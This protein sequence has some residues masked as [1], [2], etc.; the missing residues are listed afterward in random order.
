VQAIDPIPAQSPAPVV[1]FTPRKSD[2][3]ASLLLGACPPAA[4]LLVLLLHLIL[5][6]HQPFTDIDAFPAVLLTAIIL[7]LLINA[8]QFMYKPARPIIRYY[9]PLATA[10]ILVLGVWDLF[11]LKFN[12]LPAVYFPA[13]HN[14][15]WAFVTDWRE[16]SWDILAS[17]ANLSTGYLC[18]AA[19]G[20]VLGI[21][22]GWSSRVRYWAM[23]LL[24]FVGP[25]PATAWIPLAMTIMPS[26]FYTRV[27]LIAMAVWFPVAMLSASGIATVRGSYFDVARTM[28]AK[29][30]FLIFRI[31]IPAALPNIFLGLFMGLGASFLTLFPAEAVGSSKGMVFYIDRAKNAYEY[32][33]IY[34]ALL[35]MAVFFSFLITA[36]FKVRDTVLVWQKGVIK[37]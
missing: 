20:L 15:I 17:F 11:T 32:S 6:N 24:K 4:V 1:T 29:G 13:P 18:G 37:W 30:G 12:L 33:K 10:G 36:L 22:I 2:F 27:S 25:I 28:G 9:A 8:F 7:I 14:V 3:R 16:L 5:P 26:A 23:P 34:A 19:F 21:S 31:A 35:I